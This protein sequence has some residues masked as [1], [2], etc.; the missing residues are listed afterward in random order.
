MANQ[1][2]PPSKAREHGLL[3]RWLEAG[4]GTPAERSEGFGLLGVCELQTG[5][6]F[7]VSQA[8]F[9]LETAIRTAPGSAPARRAYELLE[10]ETIES[11]TGA[12]GMDLPPTVAARLAELRALAE[13]RSSE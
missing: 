11:Y 1:G 4:Q 5:N 2:L 7:W 10:A 9:Y 3:H 13:G 8:E 6:D 12:S